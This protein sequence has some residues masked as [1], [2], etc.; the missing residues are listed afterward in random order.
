M[1]S[2]KGFGILTFAPVTKAN[3]K[4]RLQPGVPVAEKTR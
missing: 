1:T 2:A 4:S 3:S